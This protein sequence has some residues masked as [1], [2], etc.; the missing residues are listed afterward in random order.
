[1]DY[2]LAALIISGLA[3]A[4]N[5]GMSIFG[6]GR[7]LSDRF[8]K[9]P[10]DTAVAKL[11]EEIHE[12]QDRSENSVGDALRAMREH[13]HSIEKAALEFRAVAA[14]TYMRRDSYYKASEDLKR[15]VNSGFEKIEQR[16][17]RMENKF[18]RKE[19]Q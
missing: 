15:D 8:A 11:R 10:T 17:Q 1:M 4:S 13:T 5:L 7:G 3:L 19:A 2:G 9:Q 12:K 16:L 6:G 18:D 14:E